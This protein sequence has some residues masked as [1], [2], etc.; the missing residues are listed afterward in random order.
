MKKSR[1]R[2]LLPLFTA[3][4]RLASKHA[5][6]LTIP[7][8]IT[9]NGTQLCDAVPVASK[10]P[11]LNGTLGANIAKWNSQAS[12]INHVAVNEG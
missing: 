6:G 12:A 7:D 10:V 3:I 2:T 4:P 9:R 11:N 8:R 1:R 5:H